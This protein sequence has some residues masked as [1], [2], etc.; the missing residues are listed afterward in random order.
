MTPVNAWG[1]MCTMKHR[2]STVTNGMSVP[3]L[4]RT[5]CD[6]GWR[7]VWLKNLAKLM[8]CTHAVQA[9]A[10]AQGIVPECA[11]TRKVG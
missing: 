10:K 4:Y 11:S 7:G 2:M 9:Q 8:P 6:C 1:I 5:E 3:P